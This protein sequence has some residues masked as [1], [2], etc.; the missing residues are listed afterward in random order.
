M[1]LAIRGSF[2]APEPLRSFAAVPIGAIVGIEVML[3][4]PMTGAAMNPARA[5]GPCVFLGHWKT[6][7]IYAVGPLAGLFIAAIV[8]KWLASTPK[9]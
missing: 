7:W 8:W 5:F 6:Y 4:G 2:A 1:M 3:M 9:P